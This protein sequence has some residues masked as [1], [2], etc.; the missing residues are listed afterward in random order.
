MKTTTVLTLVC[1][2]YVH[3]LHD[4]KQVLLVNDQTGASR[5]LQDLEAA[6]WD[7][8]N[9]SQPWS[10]LAAFIARVEGINSAQAEARL[11]AILADWLAAGFL[12]SQQEGQ[13]G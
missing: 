2:P 8:L 7:R 4:P 6:L 13:Y 1:P 5:Q 3:W 9:W 10:E 11:Q 12:T